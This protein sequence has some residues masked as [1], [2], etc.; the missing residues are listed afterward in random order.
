MAESQIK[1]YYKNVTAQII[2]D[3]H[4]ITTKQLTDLSANTSPLIQTLNKERQVGKTPYRDL[5]F[6]KETPKK[7]K[8]LVAKVKGDCENLG[9]CID[10]EFE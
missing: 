2:G 8:D 1:L 10:L 3:E 6:D 5:P 4:G 9:C 7:I